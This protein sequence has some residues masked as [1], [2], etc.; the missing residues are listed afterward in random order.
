MSNSGKL[1]VF[2]LVA[3]LA[4]IA[5]SKISLAESGSE[6]S[7]QAVQDQPAAYNRATGILGMPVVNPKGERLGDIKDVVFDLKSERVAYAVL[8]AATTP[9]KLLVVPLGALVPSGD[10]SHLVLRTDKE[11]IE[12]AQGLAANGWPAPTSRIWGAQPN[13][14]NSGPG[15]RISLPRR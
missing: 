14:A 11:K 5:T 13:Y 10:G 1:S 6:S 8:P 2:I 15:G 4:G 9:K 7:T 12:A 3:A